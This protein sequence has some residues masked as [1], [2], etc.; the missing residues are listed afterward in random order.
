MMTSK[1]VAAALCAA[2]CL[3]TGATVVGTAAPAAASGC[4]TPKTDKVT[5]T[6]GAQVWI[7]S[8]RSAGPFQWGGNQSLTTADGELSARTKGSAD[9]LGGTGGVNL[10]I[11]KAEAKYEHQWNRSTT[12]TRSYTRTFTTNSGK[13]SRK[14]HWRWRLYMKG[15]IFRATRTVTYPTP[16]VVTEEKITRRFVVPARGS[17]RSFDIETYKTRGWLHNASGDPFKP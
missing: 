14:I 4:T 16:C 12:V 17:I 1:R 3:T 8:S 11:Y 15:F 10:G 5:T 9:T 13:V 7:P 6:K 2:A